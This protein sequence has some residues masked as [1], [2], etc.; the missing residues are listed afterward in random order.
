MLVLCVCHVSVVCVPCECCVRAMLVLC[1]CHVSV[2]CVPCQCCECCSIAMIKSIMIIK[3]ES[4]VCE[5][6]MEDEFKKGCGYNIPH[7]LTTPIGFLAFP[8][9]T[10][11]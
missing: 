9:T 5:M 7:T 8:I 6:K 11:E 4:G 1:V 10:H 3:L 2:V